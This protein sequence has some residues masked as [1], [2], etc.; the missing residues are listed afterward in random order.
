MKDGERKRRRALL[1]FKV[2]GDILVTSNHVIV[3]GCSRLMSHVMM[4][5]DEVEGV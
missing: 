4:T 1:R 2:E 3:L 5:R